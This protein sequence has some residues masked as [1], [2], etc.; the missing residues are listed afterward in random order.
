MKKWPLLLFTF[1]MLTVHARSQ[2]A[3]ELLQRG[4]QIVL[5]THKQPDES[6]AKY[7]E[8][9]KYLK[10]A[11]ELAPDNPE[12]H[13]FLGSAYDYQAFPDFGEHIRVDKQSSLLASE[14]FE[15]VIRLSPNYYGEVIAL[16]PYAK[17]AS[18]W[19]CLGFSYLVNNRPDSAKWAF[20]EGRRRGGFSD[21]SLEFYRTI[22]KRLQPNT[23][24]V[25]YG[26]FSTMNIWYLQT[27]EHLRNDVAVL[28]I[29]T[30]Q[31]PWVSQF[32][33]RQHPSIFTSAAVVNDTIPNTQWEEQTISIAIGNSDKTFQWRVPPRE[34]G[35]Y[36]YILR[37]DRM[38]IDIVKNTRLTK[39]V[40][41]DAGFAMSEIAG[42]GDY[43][44]DDIL[45][46]RLSP[47]ENKEWAS[48]YFRVVEAFPF[49]LLTK[50]D[51][52]HTAETDIAEIEKVSMIVAISRLMNSGRH[53]EAERIYMKLQKHMPADKFPDKMIE[54]KNARKKLEEEF[55]R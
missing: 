30:I 52:A 6:P 7:D 40:Y 44:L 24:Y 28:N 49:E 5:S 45:F 9:I 12:T 41:F 29:N 16:D 3:A 37:S 26:D 51:H 50:I 25:T 46:L 43:L 11:A 21:F 20:M 19:G 36:K 22:L 35:N 17:I 39:P 18:I 1:V 31:I 8:A 15:R 32:I 13:Y 54:I 55:G 2:T 4:K 10:K 42:L 34:Y 47:L 48:N 23:T 14:E 38:L 33:Y 53:R 27:V